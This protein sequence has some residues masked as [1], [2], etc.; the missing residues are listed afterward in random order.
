MKLAPTY[1]RDLNGGIRMHV[2]E[3]EGNRYRMESGLIDGARVTS[4]WTEVHGK[5]QGRSNETSDEEQA[6]KVANRIRQIRLE[7][8]DYDN[9]EDIDK[10][11]RFFQPMLASKYDAV[12]SKIVDSKNDT[13][14]TPGCTT[15]VQR[16]LDGI[17]LI[18]SLGTGMQSRTG[19]QIISAPHIFRKLKPFFEKHPDVIFDGEL[20]AHSMDDNFNEVI[21]MARKTKPTEEDL[22]LSEAKLQYWIYDLPSCPGNFSER[23]AELIKI[24]AENPD[25]F[26]DSFVFVETLEVSRPSLI[27]EKYLEQFVS[28]GFEGA[29]VRLDAPYECKRSK[30]LLKV[31][32]FTDEE[33]PIVDIVEGRG[34]LSGCAGNV[35]VSVDGKEV[36]AGMKFSRDDAREIWENR[37]NYIGK[38]ATIKYFNRTQDGSLRFPKCIQIA[39]EDYE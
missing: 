39:R 14:K 13:F 33:F 10:G 22:K 20:Y 12:E 31:K 18:T 34:N 38:M 23:N 19:K 8:G 37:T 29:I 36:S 30:N 1:K 26:D 21:S 4:E 5:N 35:V 15:F 9:I 7:Q 27:K 6:L 2:I 25:I 3:V 32:Q 28:E 16:K 24:F 11:K 17:R